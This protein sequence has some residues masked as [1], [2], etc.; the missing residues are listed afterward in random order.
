MS[1][2]FVALLRRVYRETFERAGL[3]LR[4]R[5]PGAEINETSL[6]SVSLYR[7]PQILIVKMMWEKR[8]ETEDVG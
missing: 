8:T 5:I 7:K 1:V 2:G 6:E 4:V 3:G